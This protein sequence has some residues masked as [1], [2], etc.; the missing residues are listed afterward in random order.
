MSEF[1]SASCGGV[2]GISDTFTVGSLWT[3]DYVL[4]M[5]SVGYSAAYIHTRETGISYNLV[6]LPQDRDT[7][8]SWST[9]P[10]Y[11][12]LLAAAEIL[13]SD[14]GVAVVDLDVNGSKA[15]NATQSGYAVFDASTKEVIRVVLFN[16]GNSSSR[17]SLPS[18]LSTNNRVGSSFLAR[19]LSSTGLEEKW[20]IAWGGQTFAGVGDGRP[21]G[22]SDSWVVQDMQVDCQNGCSID[23]PGPALAVIMMPGH[24]ASISYNGVKGRFSNYMFAMLSMSDVPRR[25]MRQHSHS[26][27]RYDL[28]EHRNANLTLHVLRYTI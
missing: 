4:Q 19:F 17:F 15:N 6:A 18:G 1:N 21:V 20:N 24:E 8:G 25:D 14:N 22:S 10:P 5:A 2:P 28:H 23:V 16:Y 12:S 26:R 11:Y 7:H 9:N 3:M 27:H 13:Q